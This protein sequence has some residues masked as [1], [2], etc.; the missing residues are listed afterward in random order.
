MDIS[1]TLIKILSKFSR[2]RHETISNYFRKKG[3][4]IGEN[5]NI[6]SNICTSESYL[7]SVG[8]NTTISTEVLL[9]T[10]DASIGKIYG[11][12][13]ASDLVGEIKIGNNCFIGA[14]STIL[15]GVTLSDNIIVAAG[16]VVTK[17]FKENNI[18]IGGNPARIISHW[19]D[20]KGK[21][22]SSVY[23]LHGKKGDTAKK[24]ILSNRDRMIIR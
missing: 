10:H 14:R 4:E 1:Y 19:N 15:Y 13:V 22:E 8:N 24:I 12:E 7:I 6:T 20:F 3:V 2:N 17:S 23:S 5:C 18:I 21:T 11:K 16:S 9:I